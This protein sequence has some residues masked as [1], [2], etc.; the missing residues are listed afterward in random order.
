MSGAEAAMNELVRGFATRE[1]PLAADVLDQDSGHVPQCLKD[2][3]NYM[4]THTSVPFSNYYDR[5]YAQLELEHVW[6]KCWQFACRE[7]DVPNVGDRFA[8]DVGTLSFVIVRSGPAEFRAFH[9]SCRHRGTRLCEG[10]AGGSDIRCPFHGWRW[11]L[12]GSVKNIPH[13]WDFPNVGKDYALPEIRIDSW[14]GN[15]L[16]NPDPDCAPLVDALGVLP[17]HFANFDLAQRFT[18]ARTAKK[19]KANWKTAWAAFLEAYHLSEIHS[20]YIDIYAD[21][22]TKYDIF[23]SGKAKISRSLTSAAVASP[24]LADKVTSREA[25]IQ[26]LNF[27]AVALG[28]A[29][30]G[31]LPDVDNIPDFGRKHVAAWRRDIMH[32]MLGVDVSRRSDAEILDGIQYA[33]FPNWGP[34]L[35]EGLPIMYQF[36]PYGDNPDE[37]LFVIRLMAPLPDGAGPIPAA[38]MTHLDFDE[39]FDSLAEWQPFGTVLDQDMVILPRIQA[40]LRAAAASVAH[41]T[42]GRYQ[43]QRIALLHEFVEERIAEGTR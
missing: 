15:L 16:V 43:E 21:V 7:E 41:T 28:D 26:T 17:A 23:D 9:N 25:A 30:A 31:T 11:N 34:W 24:N 8:Y 40:G 19:V 39:Y 32:S 22:A 4:P 42:L 3:G 20:D 14:G 12:D 18:I 33:M 5:D 29:V 10:S 6:K 36:L 13:D 27:Y 37:S 38:P 35:G 2:N 1:S